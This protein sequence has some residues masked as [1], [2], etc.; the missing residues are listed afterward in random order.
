M[1]LP[2]QTRVA[3]ESVTIRTGPYALEGELA[4]AEELRN[5]RGAVVLVPPHPLLGGNMLNNVVRA[6][7]EGLAQQELVT[8]RFNYRGVGRSEGPHV[9]VARHLAEFWETSH[10][11]GELDLAE[12]L[13]AACVFVQQTIGA[14][15]P[16][17]LIG[18]S[19]GCVLLPRVE[20][21]ARPAAL[22]LVA[23]PLD[24][25]D[26]SEFFAAKS[27]LLII[28]S[29]DDF[30]AAAGTLRQWFAQ[31]PEPRRLVQAPLDNHFFRGHENWLVETVLDFLQDHGGSTCVH[32]YSSAA[33]AT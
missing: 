5:P 22:V 20:P 30:A 21:S 2:A 3:S 8:L 14:A 9:D 29:E 13:D 25:H 33:S 4:Y 24:K 28:A 19:F 6:L 17:V 27:P 32:L 15:V 16:L 12:D 26:C 18:Y 11:S 31:L 7:G 23:P 10:V 1:L